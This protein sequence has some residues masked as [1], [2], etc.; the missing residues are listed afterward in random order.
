M[1]EYSCQWLDVNDLLVGM[2]VLNRGTKYQL[3]QSTELYS[4]QHRFDY[5]RSVSY[6]RISSTEQRKGWPFGRNFS[7]SSAHALS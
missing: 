3:G 2:G 5:A 4:E 7:S 1:K 6:H